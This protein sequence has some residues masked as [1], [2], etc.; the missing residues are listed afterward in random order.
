MPR[1]GAHNTKPTALR[2]LQGRTDVRDD[3]P[4]PEPLLD[5]TPPAELDDVAREC[6]QRNAP[7][8]ANMG[9]LSASD[10]D[11]LAVYCD[12]YSQWR[13]TSRALRRIAPTNDNYRKVAVSV[14]KARDQM[15]LLAGEFGMTPSSRSRLSVGKA[16]DTPVDEMEGLLSGRRS[17]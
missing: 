6:W 10:A 1:G 13:R 2:L 7:T 16:K 11:L 8:L 5:L 9:V 14:E 12:A 4:Q 15:R 3:E 17:G